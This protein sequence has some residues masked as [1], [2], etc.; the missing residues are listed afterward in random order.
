MEKDKQAKRKIGKVR[1]IKRHKFLGAKSMSHGYEMYSMGNK[2]N[3][4]A[5]IL[6]GDKW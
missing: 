3:K 5:I 4:Y 2:V 6:Y 1:V